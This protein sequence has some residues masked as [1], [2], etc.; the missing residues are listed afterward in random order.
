[1]VAG[2]PQAT[3]TIFD[4]SI[5][6]S[7]G[8]LSRSFPAGVIQTAIVRRKSLSGPGFWRHIAE[9]NNKKTQE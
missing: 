7:I 6:C 8:L 3:R 9:E 5:F 1:M 2:T 4:M